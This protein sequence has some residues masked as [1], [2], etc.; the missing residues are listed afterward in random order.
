MKK[1]YTTLLE[2]IKLFI[3]IFFVLFSSIKLVHADPNIPAQLAQSGTSGQNTSSSGGQSSSPSDNIV[4]VSGSTTIGEIVNEFIQNITALLK[5][6]MFMP[7]QMFSGVLNAS[8]TSLFSGALT[9]TRAGISRFISFYF[10][11]GLPVSESQAFAIAPFARNIEPYVKAIAL[12]FIPLGII[13][14]VITSSFYLIGN[15]NELTSHISNNALKIGVIIIC[16]LMIKPVMFTLFSV[17]NDVVAAFCGSGSSCI[18]RLGILNLLFP[19]NRDGGLANG[20]AFFVS[21]F[22]MS[23]LIL[24][25]FFKMLAILFCV[26]TAPMAIT[27]LVLPA[28]GVIFQSWRDILVKTLLV[29]VATAVLIMIASSLSGS[30]SGWF[31]KLGFAAAIGLIILVMNGAALALNLGSAINFATSSFVSVGQSFESIAKHTGSAFEDIGR[32]PSSSL[33]PAYA[34]AYNGAYSNQSSYQTHNSRSSP[35][36]ERE[37]VHRYWAHTPDGWLKIGMDE[38]GKASMFLQDFIST[39]QTNVPKSEAKQKESNTR[40]DSVSSSS[41]QEN[42]AQ[43]NQEQEGNDNKGNKDARQTSSQKSRPAGDHTSELFTQF[44]NNLQN[45]GEGKSDS[46]GSNTTTTRVNRHTQSIIENISTAATSGSIAHVVLA[47]GHG[48]GLIA[49]VEKRKLVDQEG[50]ENLETKTGMNGR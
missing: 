39:S 31:A 21:Q 45:S 48:S 38:F 15:S 47:A 6:R 36:K 43:Q 27:S 18:N 9:D 10:T 28:T 14:L 20:M 23:T 41:Y 40:A 50:L 29:H 5:V 17:I 13:F 24:S 11:R 7:V 33:S 37:A 2:K 44:I 19:S 12:T 32:M 8:V 35:E 22:F 46:G 42:F 1:T 16:Y 26:L 4:A 25:H 34:H 3:L 49:E 30:L